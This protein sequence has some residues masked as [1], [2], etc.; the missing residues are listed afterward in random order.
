MEQVRKQPDKPR[1][2]TPRRFRIVKLEER[3]APA[4]G[5]IPG[6]PGGGGPHSNWWSCR[7]GGC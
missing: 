1:T 3:I 2:P 4:K 5:G 6:A 7:H